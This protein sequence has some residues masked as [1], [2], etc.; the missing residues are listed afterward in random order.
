MK[1]VEVR[2]HGLG[3]EP[4][5]QQH[6]VVLREVDGTRV[7]PIFVGP[8]EA[9]AIARMLKHEAFPRPLTHDLLAL[10][11]E[12]LKARVTRV[13]IAELREGTYYASLVLERGSEVVS[14]DARPSDSIAV[15]LR[16]Q[17]PFFVNEDLLQSPPEQGAESEGPPPSAGPSG[18][19][20]PGGEA[21]DAEQLRRF[22][23]NLDPEDF[24]KFSH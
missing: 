20:P 3:T 17:A 5:T 11:V 14:I 23:E 6:V 16:T 18:A 19:A 15:A 2:I 12:G 10:I 13:V 7:L 9:Q 8:F 1:V 24:G 22:L 21:K 4:K